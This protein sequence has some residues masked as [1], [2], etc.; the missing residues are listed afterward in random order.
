MREDRDGGYRVMITGGRW[1]GKG[2]GR[3]GVIAEMAMKMGILTGG[4]VTR[5]FSS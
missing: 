5:P 4:V 3:A 2:S 1:M